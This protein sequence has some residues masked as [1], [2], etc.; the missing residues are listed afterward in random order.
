M[1]DPNCLTDGWC[2]DP[3]VGY[4]SYCKG[5]R[6]AAEL[7]SERAAGRKE[8]IAEL[9][10]MRIV[11]AIER[12]LNDRR[13][14]HLSSLDAEIRRSIRKRWLELV[15]KAI[16]ALFAAQHSKPKKPQVNECANC[17]SYR[18]AV[19]NGDLCQECLDDIEAGEARE[20]AQHSAPH[21]TRTVRVEPPCEPCLLVDEEQ[22]K[23]YCKE[24]GRVTFLVYL[25]DGKCMGC[26]D[27]FEVLEAARLKQ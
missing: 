13:G 10:P 3:L 5:K 20:A 1:S 11:L 7:A 26:Q 6:K 4:C 17:G 21:K 16:T 27:V 14:F 18:P 22:L 12:D 9:N 15:R 2:G 24:C 25:K 8:A 19:G 23:T